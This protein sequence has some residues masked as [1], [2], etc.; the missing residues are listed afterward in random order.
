MKRFTREQTLSVKL[1]LSAF[2]NGSEAHTTASYFDLKLNKD[3]TWKQNFAV[4]HTCQW[5]VL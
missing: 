1:V 4:A 5:C 2:L 3:K